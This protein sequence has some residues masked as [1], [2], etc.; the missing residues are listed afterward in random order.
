MKWVGVIVGLLLIVSCFLPWLSIESK[1]IEISGFDPGTTKY[2]KP[3]AWHIVF[4]SVYILGL[5]MNRVWSYQL[6]FFAAAINIA[7]MLRNFIRLAACEA[8]VCPVR[9]IGLYLLF[10]SSIL[11]IVTVAFLASPRKY[12]R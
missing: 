8:G 7:W 6:A 4:T 2:G 12:L 1:A 3:G 11:M 9:E 5:L 10:T